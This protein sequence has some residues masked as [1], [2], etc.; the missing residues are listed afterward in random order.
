MPLSVPS[1]SVGETLAPDLTICGDRSISSIR[2]LD[3]DTESPAYL[4]IDDG[5][6][7]WDAKTIQVQATGLSDIGV[8]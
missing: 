1:D 8:H 3:T 4:T 2:D 7:A 6:T 5:A